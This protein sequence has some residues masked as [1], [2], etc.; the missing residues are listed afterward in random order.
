MPFALLTGLVVERPLLRVFV[1]MTCHTMH[2]VG[3]DHRHEVEVL[4][5]S[6]VVGGELEPVGRSLRA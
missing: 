1:H 2:V 6:D 5:G 4:P 3:A